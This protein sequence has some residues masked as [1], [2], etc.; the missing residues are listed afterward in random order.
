MTDAKKIEPSRNRGGRWVVIGDEQWK[1]P[2]L[3]FGAIRELQDDVASLANMPSGRPSNE[4]MTTVIRLVHSAM[5][6]NYPELKLTEVEDMLDLGN[7]GEVLNATLS[8]GGFTRSEVPASGEAQPSASTGT[9]SI[10]H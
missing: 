4:Q 8:I 7:F 3:G 10:S 6:R 5:V 1:I 2:P 9:A